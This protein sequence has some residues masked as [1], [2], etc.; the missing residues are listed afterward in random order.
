MSIDES[1]DYLKEN[2]VLLYPTDTVWG[3]GCDAT[4]P[5][6]VAKIYK[7][8]NR[9]ESKSLILLVSSLHMLQRYVRKPFLGLAL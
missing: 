5:A 3:L 1:L 2:K 6:A 4:D 9:E 7:I 8:K